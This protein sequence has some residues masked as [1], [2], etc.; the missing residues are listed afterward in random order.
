MR[1]TPNDYDGHD[2]AYNG[3][4]DAV[5]DLRKPGNPAAFMRKDGAGAADN[6]I[7]GTVGIRTRHGLLL[8]NVMEL[9]TSETFDVTYRTGEPAIR[10][11]RGDG[12]IAAVDDNETDI[13][14][15]GFIEGQRVAFED[16]PEKD[17]GFNTK[18]RRV[19]AA[20]NAQAARTIAIIVD[21]KEES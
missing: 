4:V 5:V 10:E 7:E 17:G 12:T 1:K 11:V 16:A 9:E 21:T 2:A 8:I 18:Q 15:L 20:G 6:F 14:A 13:T 19:A 3:L